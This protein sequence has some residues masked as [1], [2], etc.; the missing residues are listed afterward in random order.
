MDNLTN[1]A[2]NDIGEIETD[3][4]FILNN[5]PKSLLTNKIVNNIGESVL[6]CCYIF[7]HLV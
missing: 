7:V 1:K 6:Y 4:I 5:M 3:E 2:V